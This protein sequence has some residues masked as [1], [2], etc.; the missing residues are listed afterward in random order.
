MIDADWLNAEIASIKSGLI[1]PMAIDEAT[2]SAPFIIG[3]DGIMTIALQGPLMKAAS[4]F[5]GTST[6]AVRRALRA[7]VNDP[8]IQGIMLAIDSP[9]GAVA[10]MEDLAEDVVAAAEVMPVHAF[11]DSQ[12]ASAAYWVASQAHTISAQKSALVGSLG[13]LLVVEDTSKAADMAGV[14]V[15]VLSTGPFK[16]MGVPGSEVTDDHLA[17]MFR[18][19]LGLNGMFMEAVSAGRGLDMEHVL[20]A[21]DGSVHMGH[22]ALAAG[23]IDKVQNFDKAR[24]ELVDEVGKRRT[25]RAQTRVREARLR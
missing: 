7:A 20:A 16:G 14:K 12:G 11:I 18:N 6:I 21:A 17:E 22:E 9:G 1:V 5:G 4:K 23:L 24:A 25:V 19:V 3:E 8:D 10:G 13:T 15:H 2:A